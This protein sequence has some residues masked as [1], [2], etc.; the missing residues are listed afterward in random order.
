MEPIADARREAALEIQKLAEDF[1]RDD[2]AAFRRSR[3]ACWVGVAIVTIMIMGLLMIGGD[4]RYLGVF[5][6]IIVGL[7]WAGYALSSRRQRQQTGRLR[8]LATRWRSVGPM[9]SKDPGVGSGVPPGNDGIGVRGWPCADWPSW[10]LWSW[11]RQ[12][13]RSRSGRSAPTGP[14]MTS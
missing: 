1:E 11:R 5:W 13:R 2:E 7:T 10:R 8:A 14:A 3:I 4:W 9:V 12:R 6:L